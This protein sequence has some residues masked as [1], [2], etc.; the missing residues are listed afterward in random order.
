MPECRAPAAH[1][2]H[3]H[4]IV[5][6][7]RIGMLRREPIVDGVAGAVDGGREPA[8]I[9]QRA[10]GRADQIAAAVEMQH[11]IAARRIRRRDT[12]GLDVAEFVLDGA[13]AV[14]QRKVRGQEAVIGL[15]QAVMAARD[16][17]RPE[18]DISRDRRRAGPPAAAAACLRASR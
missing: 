1:D 13:D 9:F 6:R 14:G 17:L 7:R 8:R 3:S 4:G 16:V 12:P 10:L 15:A 11:D 2:R 5:D 18:R